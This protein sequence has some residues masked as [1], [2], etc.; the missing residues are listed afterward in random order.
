MKEDILNHGLG[1]FCRLWIVGLS[2]Y[3][4]YNKSKLIIEVNHFQTVEWKSREF[5]LF[6]EGIKLTYIELDPY[7]VWTPIERFLDDSLRVPNEFDTRA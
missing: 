4:M 2:F 3:E 5:K 6:L 7:C 1:N